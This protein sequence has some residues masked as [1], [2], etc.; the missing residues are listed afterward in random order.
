MKR[1]N[2]TAS[3]SDIYIKKKVSDFSEVIVLGESSKMLG[4]SQ[5]TIS[6]KVLQV[7]LFVSFSPVV[8]SCSLASLSASTEWRTEVEDLSLWDA[9][10]PSVGPYALLHRLLWY[11]VFWSV[12]GI[13]QGVYQ[14]LT[15]I[16]LMLWTHFL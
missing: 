2:S 16:F 8:F 7:L 5:E 12:S 4:R 14:F 6:V 9:D 13:T 3:L 15:K 1:S 11:E 10:M